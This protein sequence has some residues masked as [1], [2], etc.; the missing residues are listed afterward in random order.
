MYMMF[1]NE[2]P[3]IASMELTNKWEA[4][5]LF[6]LHGDLMFISCT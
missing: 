2:R 1:I 4:R 6:V 5:L 3:V